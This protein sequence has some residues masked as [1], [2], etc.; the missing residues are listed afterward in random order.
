MCSLDDRLKNTVSGNKILFWAKRLWFIVLGVLSSQLKTKW[1]RKDWLN[2]LCLFQ[3]KITNSRMNQYFPRLWFFV[4]WQPRIR[5][6]ANKAN[7]MERKCWQI[8]HFYCNFFSQQFAVAD[9]QSWVGSFLFL[10]RYLILNLLFHEA[11]LFIWCCC[12]ECL[13]CFRKVE[14]NLSQILKTDVVT[15]FQ[16]E[17]LFIT[18]VKI[19]NTSFYINLERNKRNLND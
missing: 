19:V 16:F 12:D 13:G 5:L 10:H 18:G 7:K 11:F 6:I 8:N 1:L 9:V 2:W 3:L 4:P 17:N 14:T 15:T